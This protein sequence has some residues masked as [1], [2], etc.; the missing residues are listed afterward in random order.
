MALSRGEQKSLALHKVLAA[1]VQADPLVLGVV[2]ERLGW[3]RARNPGSSV[4]YDRWLELVDGDVEELVMAMTGDSEHSCALRQESPF[5]DL[6]DQRER[7][8]IFREVAAA[9][10]RRSPA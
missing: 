5:V 4:Y 2:R 1:K 9:I 8:R 3:L 6:V 10:D 7:A